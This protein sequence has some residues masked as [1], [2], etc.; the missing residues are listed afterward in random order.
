M[1]V[2]NNTNFTQVA[3]TT[4]FG[5]LDA[6]YKF[7]VNNSTYITIVT[8]TAGC[9][10]ST[11]RIVSGTTVIGTATFSGSTA[12]FSGSGVSITSGGTYYALMDNGTTLSSEYSN[13]SAHLPSNNTDINFPLTGNAVYQAPHSA[14]ISASLSIG[15]NGLGIVS[16]TTDNPPVPTTNYLKGRKRSR[17]DFTGVSLG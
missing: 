1:A 5:N 13:V 4:S 17:V 9:N 12:T 2:T 14:T 10:A 16:I 3:G 7:T 6:G 15:G 8:K 11:V